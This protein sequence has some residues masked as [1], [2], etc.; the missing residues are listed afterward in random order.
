MS[1]YD[2]S[3]NAYTFSFIGLFLAMVMVAKHLYVYSLKHRV[4]R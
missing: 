1:E 3:G 4:G 2:G